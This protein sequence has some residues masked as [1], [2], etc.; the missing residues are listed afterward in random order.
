MEELIWALAGTFIVPGLLWRFGLGETE[1]WVGHILLAGLGLRLLF[2]AAAASERARDTILAAA[3]GA[4][5]GIL[6]VELLLFSGR[7]PTPV[8]IW[9]TIP[10]LAEVRPMTW[11]PLIV[12]PA[13]ALGYAVV[14]WGVHVFVRRILW[15]EIR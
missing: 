1:V 14:G 13:A 11:W 7:A 12:P 2:T 9:L 15:R 10:V 5:V 4:L 6:G 3:T 8:P